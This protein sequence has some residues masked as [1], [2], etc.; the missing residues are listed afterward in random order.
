MHL[1]QT[2]GN[3]KKKRHVA[4]TTLIW[5]K[6]IHTLYCSTQI[7][8]DFWLN[9]ARVSPGYFFLLYCIIFNFMRELNIVKGELKRKYQHWIF[10]FRNNY[11]SR[12]Y[13]CHQ[14]VVELR[15]INH[16][17]HDF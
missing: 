3:T 11:K 1:Y 2:L 10:K 4:F 8:I 5:V 15:I 12:L 17:R 7:V 14:F 13:Y 9:R 16:R 6:I